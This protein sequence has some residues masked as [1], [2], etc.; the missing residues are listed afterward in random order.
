MRINYVT[1]PYIPIHIIA[2]NTCDSNCEGRLALAD[3]IVST[4]ARD[5]ECTHA[6]AQVQYSPV[7]ERECATHYLRVSHN[8][9]RYINT[10]LV[11]QMHLAL[12]HLPS[13]MADFRLITRLFKSSCFFNSVVTVIWYSPVIWYPSSKFLQI[14]Y[15][16]CIR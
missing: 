4:I 7:L 8:R 1:P 6:Q 13:N 2:I 15:K 16:I 10:D 14:S 3:A 12:F 5:F 11:I 9:G